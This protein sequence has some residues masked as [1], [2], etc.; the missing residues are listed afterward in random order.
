MHDLAMAEQTAALGRTR[1]ALRMRPPEVIGL[2]DA[3]VTT[4]TPAAP[5]T[6]LPASTVVEASWIYSEALDRIAQVWAAGNT[7]L[8]NWCMRRS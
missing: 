6:G 5:D 4:R 7:E 8:G 2:R 3:L 1:Q